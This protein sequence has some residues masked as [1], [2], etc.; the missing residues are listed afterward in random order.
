MC[1]SDVFPGTSTYFNLLAD[2]ENHAQPFLRSSSE[3]NTTSLLWRITRWHGTQDG[4]FLSNTY[5]FEHG[6]DWSGI[7]RTST[8]AGQGAPG[9]D[10]AGRWP[11]IL[12]QC[13]ASIFPSKSRRSYSMWLEWLSRL[14]S[15]LANCWIA[16]ASSEAL[17]LKAL[18]VHVVIANVQSTLSS[19]CFRCVRKCRIPMGMPPKR[20]FQ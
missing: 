16:T 18:I 9:W 6:F 11:T 13:G 5:A 3:P 14:L 4:K 7:H 15:G 8:G 10:H 20:R 1:F 2:Q 12:W 17:I 19:S